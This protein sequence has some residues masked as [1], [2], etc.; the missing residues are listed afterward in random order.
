[1]TTL[2]ILKQAKAAK[3]ELAKLGSEDKNNA[4]LAMAD[5]L[6][7]NCAA[8]LEENKKDVEAARGKITDV[9]ID[10][11]SLDEGRIKGMADGIRDVVKLPDPVGRV[12]SRVELSNGLIVEKTAVPMGVVAIIYESRPNVSSDAAALA[13]K[14]GNVCVLRGGKEAFR[15]A[16]AIVNALRSGLKKLGLC[17]NF[18]NMVQD[19]TRQS[20]TELMTADGY[21]DLLIPRGGAGLIKACVENAT[22]PVIQTGTGI[23]H[24]YVDDDA[25]LDMAL[26]IIE[27]AKTSRP[28]VCNAEEVLLVNSKIADK[29]LPMLKK[30]LV[31]GRKENPVELRLDE[32][33]ARIIDGTKAGEKDFDTEFLNYILAVG[34]VDS[35]EEAVRHIGEHSTQHSDAII[36][37]N[38]A[39]AA[40]FTRDVDSA[41]VY[42]NA[43]TRFTDGGCFGLGCEMGI[44]TQK[45]H[46]RGPMGL[47]ELTTYKYIVKG[48]GQIR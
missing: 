42:V 22:V 7:E 12:L 29:F 38:D 28:S 20:S 33:A 27:N 5:A 34:I 16:N 14:S 10:R 44:S 46:A 30:R 35:V 11:L 32:R 4:L 36:T 26:N 9:M 23:C 15:S 13:L 47:C 17:E 43:S 3:S 40:E 48:N 19:T 18:I 25:D 39:H 1:M 6:R 21:I 31:D 2:D 8:I 41:A 45:L 24:I 37:N